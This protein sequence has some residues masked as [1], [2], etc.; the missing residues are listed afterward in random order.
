MYEHE[1]QRGAVDISDV[2]NTG[3]DGSTVSQIG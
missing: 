2:L 1:V 3:Y